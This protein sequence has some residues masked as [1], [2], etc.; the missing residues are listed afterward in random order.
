MDR[1]SKIPSW[2][3]PAQLMLSTGTKLFRGSPRLINLKV[4]FFLDILLLPRYATPY[5]LLS[6]FSLCSSM[7]VS[8]LVSKLPKTL[9]LFCSV[10]VT[11]SVSYLEM[12]LIIYVTRGVTIVISLLGKLA[13]M[14]LVN[15]LRNN[16]ILRVVHLTFFLR[17]GYIKEDLITFADLHSSSSWLVRQQ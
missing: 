9:V 10:L 5:V 15:R 11:M 12:K 7:L 1:I 6:M 8:R 3:I 16:F 4:L 13:F 14:G 2:I 17:L